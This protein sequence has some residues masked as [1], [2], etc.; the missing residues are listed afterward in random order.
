MRPYG[1]R[2]LMS[3]AMSVACVL[4][5]T[6]ADESKAGADGRSG[7]NAGKEVKQDG[8]VKL[9]LVLPKP[10]FAGTPADVKS[11]NLEAPRK[12]KRPD[13]MVPAGT[14]NVAL[15]KKVTSSDSEPIVGELSM[16]TDGDKEA[17]DGSFLE[18]GPGR[19]YVQIDLG[20]VH[21][22]SAV[23]VWHYH[24]Q[25][26]VFRDVIVQTAGD[27][28]FITNVQTVFNNDH[29]NSSGMGVGQDK[30][31]VDTNEGKLIDAKGVK[32]RYVRCYSNGSTDGEGNLYCEVEVYAKPAK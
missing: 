26:K 23:V 31:Y 25:V 2:I 27:A 22:L 16:V 5:V 29:D 30:E 10:H 6:G 24:G 15:G 12:G 11:S 32:A 20:A 8:L 1:L 19:Q 3:A 7:A 21:E 28:D 17:I 18:L 13:L 9:E 4:Q 14:T